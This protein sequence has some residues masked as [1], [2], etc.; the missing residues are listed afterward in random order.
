MY[1]SN[2]AQAA[3][4]TYFGIGAARSQQDSERKADG[5][6]SNRDFAGDIRK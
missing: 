4:R 1:F 6:G 5:V 2:M 3:R